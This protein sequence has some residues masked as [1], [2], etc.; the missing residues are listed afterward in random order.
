MTHNSNS[1]L[2]N[3]DKNMGLAPAVTPQTSKDK[4]L[5]SAQAIK[6]PALEQVDSEHS[7]FSNPKAEPSSSHL[8]EVVDLSTIVAPIS[9]RV[10]APASLPPCDLVQSPAPELV[11][12]MYVA[13]ATTTGSD[14]N[15]A[16]NFQSTLMSQSNQDAVAKEKT[17]CATAQT[18]A[19]GGASGEGKKTIVAT[20]TSSSA[21]TANYNLDSASDN[22]A[23]STSVESLPVATVAWAPKGRRDLSDT[24]D[25]PLF[26]AEGD[27]AY[28]FKD[29]NV[30]DDSYTIVK[31]ALNYPIYSTFD[32]KVAGQFDESIAGR[33]VKVS[34]GRNKSKKEIGIIVGRQEY[35][36]FEPHKIK[37]ATL[38]DDNPV[39]T[40]DLLQTLIYGAEY[41]HYPIGQVLVL[42]L[43]KILREGGAPAYKEIPGLQSLVEESEFNA[44]LDSIRSLP[45]KELL[46]EL[47]HGPKRRRELR[48]QGF[49][50]AQELALIKKGLAQKVDMSHKSLQPASAPKSLAE[51]YLNKPLHLNTEQKA[52]LDEINSIDD[53]A[54]FL[55]NGV[56]GSGKTEVYL[57]SIAHTLL[58]GKKTLV[59]V[60]EIAL[61][62]QT[63]KRFFHRFK[64]QIATLHSTLSD[65]ERLD[66]FL[67]MYNE[68]AMILIGTRSALFTP[69][70][71]LGLIVIDEEHDSSFKQNDGFRYHTRTLA[72]YR[73]Q[74]NHCKVILGSATPSLDSLYQVQQGVYKMIFLKQRAQNS[75]M[76]VIQ[77]VDLKQNGFTPD[78]YNAGIG[79]TLEDLIGI[80]SVRHQQSILFINR[81]GYSHQ[82]FCNACEKVVQCPHCDLPMTVHRSLNMLV[83]HICNHQILIPS[84]CPYCGCESVSE[85]GVGTE[86][87]EQYLHMR[88]MDVGVER[89]DRDSVS[90]K[91]ELE[92][93]LEHIRHH[94]SEIIVGTQM[95]AKGHDFP[96]VTL[97]GILN[98]DSGLYSDDFRAL[99]QTVQLI[100]QVAGRA[101]RANKPGRVI[102]QTMFPSHQILLRLTNPKFDYTELALEMLALR[103]ALSVPPYAHQAVV[104]ANGADRD[105]PFNFLHKIIGRLIEFKDL[106]D[107]VLLT[108]V[109]PDRIE[110]KINRYHYH[111]LIN[112]VWRLK[113]DQTL[114]AIQMIVK[115]ESIPHDVRFSIDVDPFVSP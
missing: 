70:P 90:T 28:K 19:T 114:S 27:N 54:V 32:Y 39:V 37:V 81:R 98:V 20:T 56:T 65:R 104:M 34:F 95:L 107:Y 29:S 21:A 43:P 92:Q 63:F 44:K 101:G 53:Y 71:N 87:V 1:P 100:T 108:P 47:K 84:C 74:L 16:Q 5:P 78:R 99:E 18:I 88:F 23:K 49:T 9:P 111:F 109:L 7:L 24:S 40:S 48:E 11:D 105:T 67:D 64:V 85:N 80:N 89:V 10:L 79:K 45:Q 46:I 35:P 15:F 115:Q 38:L 61:T 59:L 26:G 112:C 62:P 12:P 75:K 106:L 86:Q 3:L 72:L 31:V 14:T 6:L 73:A 17:A 33:R 51:L 57:Q 36:S 41:Y 103:K 66:G 76:P 69:I 2:S 97:V 22:S 25:L 94:K 83:C 4:P 102:I 96:D 8:V 77:L 42:A 68:R 13:S 55:L 60:P 30:D 82:L 113:L 110:K 91:T 50:S 52:A 58:L 93:T